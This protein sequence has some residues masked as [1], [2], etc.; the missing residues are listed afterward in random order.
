ML[1][2]S[3]SV[4][5]TYRLR[6]NPLNIRNHD[7]TDLILSKVD[8][9]GQ[10]AENR[11]PVSQIYPGPRQS[12]NMSYRPRDDVYDD[13]DNESISEESGFVYS[14][15]R[16][17]HVVQEQLEHIRSAQ[18]QP[19]KQRPMSYPNFSTPQAFEKPIVPKNRPKPRSETENISLSLSKEITMNK[20]QLQKDGVDI[21]NL[22]I[23]TGG[24]FE[25]TKQAKPVV[26]LG[27]PKFASS[28]SSRDFPSHPSNANRQSFQLGLSLPS[29]DLSSL[30]SEFSDLSFESKVRRTPQLGR[31]N[32]ITSPNASIQASPSKAAPAVFER[33]RSLRKSQS[34]EFM[35]NSSLVSK[36]AKPTR[37]E[38]V[39]ANQEFTIPVPERSPKRPAP[40]PKQ[41]VYCAPEKPVVTQ[42][43]AKALPNPQHAEVSQ[44][45]TPISM[46]SNYRSLDPDAPRRALEAEKELKRLEE[47]K[48]AQK[49][50]M[51]IESV[52]EES[53]EE[54]IEEPS[55]NEELDSSQ[56]PSVGSPV[57]SVYSF[58]SHMVNQLCCIPSPIMNAISFTPPLGA[59][60][61]SSEDEDV[62]DIESIFSQGSESVKKDIDETSIS[63]S[64]EV[65][66]ETQES[67]IHMA[68]VS[69]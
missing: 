67:S 47:E 55:Y 1:K 3:D 26:D 43:E 69:K 40:E 9:L 49:E 12:T 29:P 56:E 21:V 6:T 4:D 25:N 50:Q 34:K 2:H 60:V 65:S 14:T 27:P 36:A 59:A 42:V 37:L 39:Y 23:P 45:P 24:S 10:M 52:Q 7:G 44:T 46:E 32:T 8:R 53:F 61:P 17:S 51:R 11:R 28:K 41:P 68:T 66:T 13:S 58:D 15:T 5:S 62:S 54:S 35:N 48:E 38:P 31:K 57:L 30:M 20:E 64:S 33:M 22:A 16:S 19:S 63:G 18:R